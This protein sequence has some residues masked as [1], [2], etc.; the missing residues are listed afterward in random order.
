MYIDGKLDAFKYWDG[1]INSSP[2]HLTIGQVLPNNNQYNF[3]GKIDDI[4]L[5]DYAL[6]L[7]NITELYE[8]TT[9]TE[10]T[11]SEIPSSTV[12]H[13]NYPN[14]FNPSTNISFS[15]K[16]TG[17]VSLSVFNMLG[18]EV[19]TILPQQ[20]MSAGSYSFQYDASALSSGVYIYRLKTMNGVQT[21]KM[22][23]IK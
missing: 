15:L 13:Q 21:Q 17:L 8:M 16:E 6:S 4:R 18:Q 23:L 11:R 2:V 7:E 20:K 10:D 22:I 9:S 3:N 14:P 12:L 1:D 5:F 19:D